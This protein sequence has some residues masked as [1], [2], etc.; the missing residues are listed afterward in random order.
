MLKLKNWTWRYIAF[1]ILAVASFILKCGVCED[2]KKP[3]RSLLAP[4]CP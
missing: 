2:L 1:E 3:F 4:H